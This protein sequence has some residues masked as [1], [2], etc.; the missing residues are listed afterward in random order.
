MEV[1]FNPTSFAEGRFRKAYMGT[2]ITPPKKAGRECVV[3]EQKD[4]YTWKAT[5]WG[6][7][8]S[9]Q[10]KA[11][12]FAKGFNDHAKTTRP[13]QFTDVEILKVTERSNPYT[14]PKLNEYVTCEDYI[15]GQYKKWISNYGYISDES[16]SLP[17]FA[18]WSWIHTEGDIMIADLQGVR[19][20][21]SYILT[22]PVLLSA[23]ADGGEYGCTDMGIE[24]MAVFFLNH[25]CNEFC[26]MFSKPSVRSAGVSQIQISAASLLLQQITN[27]TA[28]SHEKRFPAHIREALVPIF[29]GIAK[30]R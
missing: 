8:V 1:R 23:T 10:K 20:D 18:H 19:N 7:T 13:I 11:Q 22:D 6:T 27:S 4:S 26:N 29:K 5:D 12:G 15:P 24:G 9:I 17:A 2:Y 25:K 30:R 14:R 21:N 28:Y 16:K 3:K